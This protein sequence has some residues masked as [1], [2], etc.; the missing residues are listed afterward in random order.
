MDSDAHS[1]Y[2]NQLVHVYYSKEDGTYPLRIERYQSHGSLTVESLTGAE[3]ATSKT[4]VCV[5]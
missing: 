5:T 3:G 1:T 4:V 2:C